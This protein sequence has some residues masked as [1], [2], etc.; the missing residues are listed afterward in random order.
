MHSLLSPGQAPG[1]PSLPRPLRGLFRSRRAR[2]T[3]R[4]QP[5][6]P[7]P[8]TPAQV[9]HTWPSQPLKGR[10]R[11]TQRLGTWLSSHHR[12]SRAAPGL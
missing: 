5:N 4:A 11:H 10:L 8:P 2:G 9:R 12:G 6:P 3:E 1:S 7:P